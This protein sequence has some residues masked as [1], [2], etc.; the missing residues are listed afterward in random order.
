MQE[1][2]YVIVDGELYHYGV[3]GMRC[4]KRK[5]MRIENRATRKYKKAGVNLGKADYWKQSGNKT[6]KTYN[7]GAKTLENQ[8]KKFEQKGNAIGAELAKRSASAL[9]EKGKSARAEK[10]ALADRYSKK[11]EKNK[12]KAAKYTTK[13]RVDLG[14]KKI[15]GIIGES[16]KK[17]YEYA[18][19]SE[20]YGRE[21]DMK[22]AY[23]RAKKYGRR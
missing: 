8:S 18:K 7:A 9:R 15:E 13:K 10:Y 22:E 4:G 14:N 6:Y 11:A 19:G 17:G 21:Q 16:R 12:E 20:R 5:A 23:A 1:N 2:N 3:P